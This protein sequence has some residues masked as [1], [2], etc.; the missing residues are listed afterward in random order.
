M[1]KYQSPEPARWDGKY[2]VKFIPKKRR[3]GLFGELR[4]ALGEIFHELAG[5]TQEKRAESGNGY[6]R[7]FVQKTPSEAGQS[8]VIRMAHAAITGEVTES[9]AACP[10]L[11][12]GKTPVE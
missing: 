2:H 5:V 6:T 9:Q 4:G 3:K 12:L 1:K 11:R 7:R 10:I 8:I